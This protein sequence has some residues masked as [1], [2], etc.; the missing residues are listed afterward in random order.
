MTSAPPRHLPAGAKV[1]L[2][3][4]Y[5]MIPFMVLFF[6][7]WVAIGHLLPPLAP[8]MT[9]VEVADFFDAHRDRLRICMMMCMVSTVFLMTYQAA[10]IAQIARIERDGPKV[11]TYTALMAGAGNIVSFT[12][13]LMFWTVALF[14]VERAPELVQ[15][16]S[17]FAW[18]QFLG[19]LSPYVPF[20]A[21]VAIAG[22]MDKSANPVF[23]RW[24]CY[25]TIAATIAYL[26]AVMIVFFHEGWFAWNSVFGWWLPFADTFTWLAL[27]FWLV[28]RGILAQAAAAPDEGA[29]A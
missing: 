24:Y 13:P 26:P 7:G 27:T 8:S 25:Y 22:L 18:L 16:A 29:V 23:P 2:W 17:D 3:F 12:F 6:A 14:R 28:R 10:I 9:A 19:M 11:L 15:L 20:P 5:T 1:Q 21:C 4:C